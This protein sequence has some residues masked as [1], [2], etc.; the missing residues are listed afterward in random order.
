[1]SK[2]L[3]LNI[4]KGG[5]FASFI[6]L[7]F[8]FLSF[9]FPYISSKQ[10]S[11]NVWINILM[12]FWLLFI[13][14]YPK[15]IPR[16]SYISWGVIAYF[17][18]ILM[19]LAVSV[20]FNL[21]FWGD[22]ERMLGFFHLLHFLFFYFI[23]IT[24]FRSKQDFYQLLHFVAISAVL[25]GLYGIYKDVAHSTIGNRAYVAAM[26]LFSLFLQTLF[27]IKTKSWWL[28]ISYFVGIIIAF[29]AFIR[30]DISGS[31]VGLAAGIFISLLVIIFF[32]ASKKVKVIGASSL[33]VLLVLGSLL[34]AFRDRPVF[35]GNYLGKALRSFSGDNI[36]LNTRLISYKAAGEF[37]IDHP[38]SMIF[39]VGHGNYAY[40]FDQYFDPKF[41]D[42]DRSETY[43]D[44]AHNTVIDI[45]TTAG[46]LGLLA[47]LSIFVFIFIYLIK[48]YL[49]RDEAFPESRIDKPE[50]V[51]ILGLTT[52]YFVQNLAVFDSFATYLYFFSLLAFI[53]FLGFR[54]FI[55]DRDKDPVLRP[56]FKK[57]IIPFSFLLIL[58]SFVNNVNAMNM[59]KETIDS[60]VYTHQ[61]GIVEGS[62]KYRE[63]FDYNTG[64]ERD[65]R[66]AYINL[67]LDN[68]KN[69]LDS[70]NYEGVEGV[71]QLAIEAAEKNE[72][73]NIYSNLSLVR[74]SRVY[75]MAGKFYFKH[76]E[77]ERASYYSSLALDTMKRAID[78]SPGRVPLY[79]TKAN[80]LINFNEREEALELI[81]KA[82][83][84]NNKMPEAYCQLA[85]FY[86]LES[87]TDKVIE[88]FRQCLDLGGLR[89]VRLDEFIEQFEARY[90]N[91]G[92]FMPIV[93]MNKIL[94]EKE[95]SNDNIIKRLSR[96]ALLYVEMND[97]DKAREYA[98]KIIEVDKNY[99]DEVDSFLNLLNEKSELD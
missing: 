32:S 68:S 89:L 77:E 12:V 81:I 29:L 17:T 41:Y 13:M 94:L 56:I 20:D 62:D 59:V 51:I 82:R 40:I 21:S 25:V 93:E 88:N 76:G 15:Y 87:E 48:A 75:E 30:A 64:M 85:N 72:S 23:I 91:N 74:L 60:Y 37:M 38:V 80:F 11:F 86:F 28:R 95:E 83:D 53:N 79:L 43:F 55:K 19:S 90:F 52:A 22:V 98:L 27:F 8:V 45:V 99:Q 10:L 47:Y 61:K 24:V 78:S 54:F 31:H 34:F 84:L 44:R 5:V 70:S 39:G 57:I 67:V 2:K 26:M 73:Y 18:T 63:L 71:I 42:Y 66:K 36:T 35:D 7:F 58:L 97:I 33:L 69:I 96:I 1:M 9:L 4:L 65:A 50:L 14:K 49:K 46:V 6:I 3:Y 16:K 92:D